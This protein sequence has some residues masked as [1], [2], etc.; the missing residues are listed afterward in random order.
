MSL[1]CVQLGLFAFWIFGSWG[2][3]SNKCILYEKVHYWMY[4]H[5]N[6]P[7]MIGFTASCWDI[8]DLKVNLSVVPSNYQ[9]LCLEIMSGYVMQSVALSRFYALERLHLEGFLPTILLGTF[10]GLPSV[11]TLSLNCK[12]MIQ[13]NNASLLSNTFRYLTNL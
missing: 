9:T 2:W 10:K 12:G 4:I 11:K 5:A 3:L 13:C 6:C 1:V 8:Y 7:S